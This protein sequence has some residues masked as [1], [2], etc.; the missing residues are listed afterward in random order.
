MADILP[1]AAVTAGGQPTITGYIVESWEPQVGGN[2]QSEDY[3]NADGSHNS[4]IVFEKRMDRINVSLILTTGD[5]SEFPNGAMCTATGYTSY[6]CD[7]FVTTK[8]K[9]AT[10]MTGTLEKIVF[11]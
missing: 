5:G 9:G 10:R 7:G 4:R 2:I 8:N 3:Q 6:Y 11:A 1:A